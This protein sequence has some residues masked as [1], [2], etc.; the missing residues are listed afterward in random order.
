M[1]LGIEGRLLLKSG[2]PIASV[3]MFCVRDI[4]CCFDR[5]SSISDKLVIDLEAAV[6]SEGFE[7]SGPFKKE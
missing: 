7:G 1:N 3:S 5:S 4:L 6:T 2:L